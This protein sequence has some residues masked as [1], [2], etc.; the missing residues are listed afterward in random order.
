MLSDAIKRAKKEQQQEIELSLDLKENI[1]KDLE[2]IGDENDIT[3]KSL[4]KNIIESSLESEL[5]DSSDSSN[6]K[7]DKT[8][9]LWIISSKYEDGKKDLSGECIEKNQI[10]IGWFIEEGFLELSRSERENLLKTKSIRK[11]IITNLDY[12]IEKMKEGDF[13]IMKDG[14]E[15]I[16]AIV[17]I[18]SLAKSGGSYY[19]REV[20][21]VVVVEKN[22]RK[23]I[24]KL[25]EK[26]FS[27]AL[28]RT[29]IYRKRVEV[30]SF[31]SFIIDILLVNNVYL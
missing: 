25:Y 24:A 15:K 21:K 5:S 2:L 12:F 26:Y 3:L 28:N 17:Q 10:R 27:K 14:I 18:T 31:N 13:V 8:I 11:N 19:Y 4:C 23:D 22:R 1:Y 30:N 29:T 7:E 6:S 9:N 20:K 16:D